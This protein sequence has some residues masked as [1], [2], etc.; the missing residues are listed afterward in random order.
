MHVGLGLGSAHAGGRD[1]KRRELD[2]GQRRSV[3]GLTATIVALNAI[4]W[5][6]SLMFVVPGRYA[7][8]GSVF[9]IGLGVTAYTLGM[10]HARTDTSEPDHILRS[11]PSRRLEYVDSDGLPITA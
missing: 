4:G 2:T 6:V 7:V 9:G 3:L 1:A 10:R 11:K 5:G 8:E